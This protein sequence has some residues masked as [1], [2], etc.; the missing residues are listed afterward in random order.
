[1]STF[2]IVGLPH[3]G[4]SFETAH[5]FRRL[6]RRN[7]KWYKKTGIKRLI[8]SNLRVSETY[9]SK[10]PETREFIKYWENPAELVQIKDADIIWDEIARILDSRNFANLSEKVKA[11]IQEHDK[12][13]CDI[14]ANTQAPNQVDIMFRRNCEEIWK[15]TKII[16]SRRP[17]PTKPPV[18]FIWGIFWLR[19]LKR[20]SFGK[21]EDQQEF[22]PQ[23]AFGLIPVFW[24]RWLDKETCRFYDT[25]QV[26]RAKPAPLE[27]IERFCEDMN[28][29]LH[30]YGKLSHV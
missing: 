28:C 24:L 12:V 5:D 9:F 22:E 3:H 8:Y 25:R 17:S 4:K 26:I 30:H 2:L 10:Y 20:A 11:F 15:I 6:L 18:K 13:G 29:K 23:L 7:I 1:M 14:Y 19:K 16:G 21:E 27:H